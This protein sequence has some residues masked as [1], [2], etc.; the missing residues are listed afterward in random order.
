MQSTSIPRK[1]TV[2]FA[3]NADSNYSNELNDYTTQEGKASYS[4]GFPPKTMT[5][6]YKGGIPP[7]GQDMNGILHDLSK[8]AQFQDL[9][10]TPL[11]D[12]SFCQDI[13]GY[14][15]NARIASSKYAYVSFVSMIENNQNDPNNGTRPNDFWIDDSRQGNGWAVLTILSND[16]DN[17]SYLD[18]NL[19]LVTKASGPMS[20]IYVSAS[21]GS[22]SNA[23]TREAPFATPGMA[24]KS[25]PDGGVATI[26]LYYK[27]NFSLM[28]DNT[29]STTNILNGGWYI[30]KRTLTIQ[31]YGDPFLEQAT[32]DLQAAHSPVNPYNLAG[33]QR[34]IIHIPTG[35]DPINHTMIFG[36]VNG[37]GGTIDFKGID[38]RVLPGNKSINQAGSPFSPFVDYNFY[39][40][41]F[42]GLENLNFL[43]GGW[44]GN[45][46]KLKFN[47]CNISSASGAFIQL[48]NGNTDLSVSGSQSDH[49]DV[50]GYSYPPSNAM[51]FFA[52]KDNFNN[53]QMG[54]IGYQDAN[55]TKP[56]YGPKNITT[57]LN[58]IFTE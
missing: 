5:P 27:D 49:V 57:N 20:D 43:Y 28:A 48:G 17:I 14:P 15:K 33:F 53:F 25:V 42:E 2:A 13:G 11:F 51:D 30:G 9:G 19:R 23:G 55:G 44:G 22:D 7:L 3:E 39:G 21:L 10:G 56:V 26:H 46:G 31:S 6:T 41:I 50:P 45:S 29:T 4:Q 54:I 1:T 36:Y 18:P 16:P 52:R 8:H 34:T 32:K 35:I 47:F 58:W 37:Q 40:C 24:I 12:Q 38:F